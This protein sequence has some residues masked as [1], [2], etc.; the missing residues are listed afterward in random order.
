MPEVA[1][2][3]FT[4]IFLD[5]VADPTVDNAALPKPFEHNLG[6][7]ANNTTT[8]A[9]KNWVAQSGIQHHLI[10]ATIIPGGLLRLYLCP[11]W[12]Y[13]N[14][15]AN[16][17]DLDGNCFAFEGDLLDN[18]DYLVKLPVVVFHLVANACSAPTIPAIVASMDMDPTIQ[19]K[20]PYATNNADT[21]AL[22]TWHLLPVL[23]FL[24]GLLLAYPDGI[25]PC[26]FWTEVFPVINTNGLTNSCQAL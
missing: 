12:W 1:T 10:V 6:M 17:L 20:G 18:N 13:N 23:H 7:V 4:N 11:F 26:Q 22:K 25:T 24:A 5:P 19:Q 21:E 3:S 2:A 15:V 14:L 16:H 8:K 9:I